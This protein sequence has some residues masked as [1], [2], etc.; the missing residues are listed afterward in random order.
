MTT[1]AQ[2]I[3]EIGLYGRG[4]SLCVQDAGFLGCETTLNVKKLIV[5]YCQ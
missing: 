4:L 1:R 5:L 3:M 2:H